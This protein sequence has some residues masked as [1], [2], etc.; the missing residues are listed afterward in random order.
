MPEAKEVVSKI[1]IT[2]VDTN[3]IS[4]GY[5]TF[6]ELYEHRIVNYIALCKMICANNTH[7]AYVP[8]FSTTF[9]WI[10]KVH[11]DGSVWDGWFIMGIHAEPGKQITYHL[12]E[13]KWDKCAKFASVIS[14]APDY[15]GHTSEDVLKRLSEL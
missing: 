14:K 6:G 13:S 12:P 2:G 1:T 9:V 10:S 8:E 5:H 7:V 15:D 3:I 11:S 4:D